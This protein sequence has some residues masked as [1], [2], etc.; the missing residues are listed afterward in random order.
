MPAVCVCDTL[1]GSGAD[2]RT[3]TVF[4]VMMDD[5]VT[6]RQPFNYF[7]ADGG[8]MPGPS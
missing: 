2:G 8:Q 5:K 4:I 7:E 1:G 6:F 3:V